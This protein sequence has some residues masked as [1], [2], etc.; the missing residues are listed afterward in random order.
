MRYMLIERYPSLY[1]AIG[2]ILIWGHF[3]HTYVHI[4]PKVQKKTRVR[5]TIFRYKYFYPITEVI[6]ILNIEH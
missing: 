1:I 3:K 6:V 4:L 5:N 2:K